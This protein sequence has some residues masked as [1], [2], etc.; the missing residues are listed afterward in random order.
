MPE[1]QGGVVADRIVRLQHEIQA[2]KELYSWK[3]HTL[4]ARIDALGP[5][6][7]SYAQ[8]V[9]DWMIT[10]RTVVE[11]LHE[12]ELDTILAEIGV[13]N[14]EHLRK[15]SAE[16]ER[17]EECPQGKGM[18]E[19]EAQCDSAEY[20]EANAVQVHLNDEEEALTEHVKEY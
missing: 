1:H 20:Y 4:A 16:T 7:A 18:V 5:E 17:W 15:L 10:G 12:G 6:Y 3:P 9:R 13:E 11:A 14:E 2:K 19:Q 8:G